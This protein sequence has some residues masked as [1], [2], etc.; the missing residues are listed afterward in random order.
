MSLLPCGWV[1]GQQLGLCCLVIDNR[2][3]FLPSVQMLALS[4]GCTDREPAE[5]FY[6]PLYSGPIKAII[7][8]ATLF[9]LVFHHEESLHPMADST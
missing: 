8:A 2:V 5:M 4:T 1:C 6:V 9:I 7:T 3:D